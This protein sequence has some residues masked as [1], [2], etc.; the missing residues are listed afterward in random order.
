M[1]AMA[2][3]YICELTRPP[4][5]SSPDF[6]WCA[7]SQSTPRLDGVL[8]L[9]GLVWMCPEPRNGSR[10]RPVAAVS[11]TAWTSSG[12]PGAAALVS[13][14]RG[15]SRR[16]RAGGGS[17]RRAPRAR[18]A[19]TPG[20][21][22]RGGRSA[23]GRPRTAPRTG[24]SCPRRASG[25]SASGRRRPARSASPTVRAGPRS[26][27]NA[28]PASLRLGDRGRATLGRARATAWRRSGGSRTGRPTGPAGPATACRRWPAR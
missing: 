11:D 14:C 9:P 17:A 26:G 4:R 5:N 10:A 13:R 25:P 22:L 23:P 18:R 2:W 15:S 1:L 16:R 27:A 24:P 20:S 19:R 12:Q 8:V 3:L 6:C 21:P 28:A 7:R